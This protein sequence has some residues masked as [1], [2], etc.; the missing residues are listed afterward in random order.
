MIFRRLLLS[1]LVLNWNLGGVYA[2]DIS[3][4]TIGT[5][6]SS[7]LTPEEEIQFGAAFM[8]SVRLQLP[9]SNDPEVIDYIWSLG[10]KL[11]SN[12]DFNSRPFHFFV[13]NEPIIN[14]FAGPGGYIGI[15]SG[16][17]LASQDENELAAVIAHEIAHVSQRHL[18]RAFN[19][20]EKLTLPTAAAIVA[21]IILGGKDVNLAEAALAATLAANIQSQLNFTRKNELEADHIG[22]QILIASHFDPNAMP[23]FFER[24]QQQDRLY[25][26]QLPEFLRTHPVTVNRIA[27]SKGRAA[28][29][30]GKIQS[31]NVQ[32]DI[33]KEKLRVENSTN[34]SKLVN[35]YEENR[36]TRMSKKSVPID[37]GYALA[38]YNDGQYKH[39]R[40]V[41][42]SLISH[43][44]ERISYQILLAQIEYADGNSE[45]S[46]Q[47]FSD[48][49]QLNPGNRAISHYYAETLLLS[50]HSEQAIRLLKDQLAER[51]TPAVYELLAK[52][53]GENNHP[54]TALRMF[55]EYYFMYGQIHTAIEQLNLALRQKDISTADANRIEERITELKRIAIMEKE[56]Q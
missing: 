51:P 42:K 5:E 39:A 3:L 13:V 31:R 41:L 2:A 49:L 22:M 8:R 25:D 38:L 48:A 16:L 44:K 17:I 20:A 18:D 55:A 33:I 43:D 19:A 52:A 29:Y 26:D 14:A 53:E 27:E 54:G 6:A 15:N 1:I 24:L 32:Y 35:Y 50:G 4:P 34:P 10:Y 12:S 28:Q 30:K 7:R 36:K 21:A 46:L 23:R 11:V 37:Y 56:F 40:E 9:V 47:L 45:K